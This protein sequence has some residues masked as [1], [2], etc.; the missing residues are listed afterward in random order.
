MKVLLHKSRYLLVPVFVFELLLGGVAIYFLHSQADETVKEFLSLRLI[1]SIEL[2]RNAEGDMKIVRMTYESGALAKCRTLALAFEVNK[3]KE[4]LP[5]ILANLANALDIEMYSIANEKGIVEY[6][7]DLNAIGYDLNSQDQSREFL[8]ALTTPH[9]ILVQK[10]MPRGMDG[11][12]F[13]YIGI[14]LRN[15][16]GVVAIGYSLKNYESIESTI[17]LQRRMQAMRIGEAGCVLIVRDNRI[18]AA[19]DSSVLNK[20]LRQIGISALGEAGD[21]FH[22]KLHGKKYIASYESMGDLI[23]IGMV[24]ESETFG[25]VRLSIFWII[26]LQV[27]VL[28]LVWLIFFNNRARSSR[29]RRSLQNGRK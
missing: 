15:Q 12:M 9:S 16:K 28:A 8:T 14:P 29:N 26:F 18:I 19:E 5:L 2:L 13:Q 27:G 24:P 20:D 3:E 1:D 23:L 25:L 6:S 17:S 11:K 21:F 22:V 4:N 7:N 10:P